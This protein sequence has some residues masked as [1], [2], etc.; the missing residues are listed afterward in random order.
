PEDSAAPAPTPAERDAC[1][2]ELRRAGECDARE[3]DAAAGAGGGFPWT[4]V[5][6]PAAALLVLLALLA[7]LLW[8]TAVR[9]RRLGARAHAAGPRAATLAAWRELLD[10]GWD[11]G[12]APDEAASPRGAAHRLV[13]GGRLDEE[14]SAA[15]HRVATAVERTLYAPPAPDPD[16]ATAVGPGP[17]LAKDVRLVGAAMREHADRRTRLRA[18]LVPRSAVRVKWAVEDRRAAAARRL[19]GAAERTATRLRPPFSRRRPG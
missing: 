16:P 13:D 8:R 1:P 11:L 9:S 5:L 3:Q 10:T 14:A 6:L 12:V 18:L 19:R 17:E 2:P 7:P 15:A 4:A